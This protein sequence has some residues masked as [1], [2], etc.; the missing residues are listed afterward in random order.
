MKKLSRSKILV[1]GAGGF[2]GSHLCELCAAEG[3]EVRAFVHYNSRSDRGMLEDLDTKSLKN[4]EIIAGDLRDAE[5]VRK[6]VRG[7]DCVMHLGALIGIPY[8][9]ANPSDV[10]QTNVLGSL[11]VLQACL[12]YD[13]ERLVQTSTSEVYGT[14]KYTPMD[15]AHPLNPQ[16][17]Y[18]ASKV[19]SDKLAE[20]YHRT[21][22]L[23]VV[24]LR[25]FNAYGPR[26]SPRAVIPT[27]ILQ[28]LRRGSV[29]LGNLET[30]RDLT[31]VTD[32][33]KGFIAAV[34]APGI[35]GE[36]IQLGSQ[37]EYSVR[38][39]VDLVG[40]VLNKK[41]KTISDARRRRPETSEVN[42]LFA[43]NE[44]AKE[45]LLW[46]PETGM[47]EG[48]ERTVRWFRERADFY[49]SDFYHV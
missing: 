39:L 10:V 5:A 37:C 29:R 6:A 14:A 45:R 4:L 23:P 26:Q 3:A 15:E 21:Y 13:V 8:S 7:C 2:I 20:S 36:T 11:H 42:R 24:I 44:L 32:T 38:D 48:L 47:V 34:A 9:Y 18:A 17:P 40:S 43:S 46:R 30:K 25:P 41:L 22:G 27:I 49:R 1:T 16:S 31:Y 33:A 28:A 19:A 12:E 35:E